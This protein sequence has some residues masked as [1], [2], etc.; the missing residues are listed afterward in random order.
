MFGKL[1]KEHKP[2]AGLTLRSFQSPC[3]GNMFG[4]IFLARGGVVCHNRLFQSPCAGNM[5]GK[6]S[7]MGLMSQPKL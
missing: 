2:V 4:K 3:A 1:T 6:Q 5:F 7:Q